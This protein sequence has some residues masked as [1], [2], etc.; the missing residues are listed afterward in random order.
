MHTT[1][2]SNSGNAAYGVSVGAAGFFY[3]K[4]MK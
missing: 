2:L 4:A 1:S 3:K